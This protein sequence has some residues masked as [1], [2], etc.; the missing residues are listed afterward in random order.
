[1]TDHFN[2]IAVDLSNVTKTFTSFRS[3]QQ[4]LL[5]LLSGGRW[6]SV[7]RL[8]ALE[9][10]SLRLKQGD[11]LG[12]LGENGSGKSTLLK[13]ICG[14]LTPDHGAVAVNGRVSALLE[15]GAGFSEDLSGLEN[16]KQYCALH[17]LPA[18]Q[19]G[20]VLERI[21]E[22][23]EL[24]DAVAHPIKTYS[25]GMKMRLGFACAVYVQPD[26]LIVDEAL[27]VGDAYF[28]NKC[29]HKIKS[30][31]EAGTTFIYVSHASDGVKA[32]CDRAL[33]LDAG[34]IK[35][36]GDSKKVGNA[37]ESAM[38]SRSVKAGFIS[39]PVDQDKQQTAN[40]VRDAREINPKTA[41]ARALFDERV[42]ALRTGSGES[43]IV[44]VSILDS[45]EKACDTL[46]FDQEILL[47]I[48][49]ENS[50]HVVPNTVLSIGIT[51][52]HGQEIVHLSTA[53][54]NLY[55]NEI[56]INSLG[57]VDFRVPNRL[58]PG[59]YGV[60]AGLGTLERHPILQ[61]LTVPE[62][63]IDYC[64]GG[65]RFSVEQPTTM[66]ENYDLWG[67]VWFDYDVGITTSS[68]LNS[69]P[70]RSEADTSS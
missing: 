22:F 40:I 41:A 49:I 12:I 32:L 8:A 42:S 61:G 33:W 34:R 62:R 63:V 51:N 56:G 4:Q 28:Q 3:P 68:S 6:G 53:T 52:I 45:S 20:D 10:I 38:F 1:M 5:H 50:A 44:D 19:I 17:G 23:S 9:N 37:Y 36:L 66:A 25:S 16:V 55:I 67:S 27:S 48:Y 57:W 21:V 29:L 58:C 35:M 18:R 60:S 2:D 7:R 43:R 24:D 46:P 54:R 13:V 69:A 39:E 47:R 65:C 26:I 14:V 59:E 11:R 15:L 31:I 64:V 70:L 30:M